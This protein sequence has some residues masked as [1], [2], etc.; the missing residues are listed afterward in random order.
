MLIYEVLHGSLTT[1]THVLCGICS[2]FMAPHPYTH[3]NW[4]LGA[5][6]IFDDLLKHASVVYLEDTFGQTRKRKLWGRGK[7][8]RKNVEEKKENR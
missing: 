1:H 2:T 3:T 4:Q 7:K 8:T 6:S 5:H